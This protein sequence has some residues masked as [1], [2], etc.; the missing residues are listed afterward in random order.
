MFNIRKSALLIV[1]TA[2]FAGA[3]VATALADPPPWAPAHGY[4]S[5]HKVVRHEYIHYPSH[6]VY[7]S[8]RDDRWYWHEG[9]VWHHSHDRPAVIVDR[10]PSVRVFFD[11]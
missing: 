9:E 3:P 11:F 2:L 1:V 4:R 7:F 10:D 5:K 6:N 8:P